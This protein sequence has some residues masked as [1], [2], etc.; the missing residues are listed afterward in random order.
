MVIL[1]A[2][3]QGSYS[4]YYTQQAINNDVTVYTIGLGSGVN[5]AL[6]TNIATS[7]D[8]QYFPV[9]SAE[10]LPDVFRTISGEIEPT[11][12]DVGGLLDGEEAGKLVEYNGKQYFQLFSDPITEQ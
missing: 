11:D 12:T 10:D 7:A 2:D 1:L 9:S 5:S 6:L 3:G 4:D 8:G